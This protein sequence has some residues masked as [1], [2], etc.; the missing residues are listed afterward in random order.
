MTDAELSQQVRSALLRLHDPI[1]LRADPLARGFD[2]WSQNGRSSGPGGARLR[3]ELLD[4]IEALK[5]QPP[6]SSNSRAL[7]LYRLLQLRYVEGNDVAEV[8][9]ELA[10]SKSQYYREHEPALAALVAELQDRW[11]GAP[12]L[13]SPSEGAAAAGPRRIRPEARAAGLGR[14]ILRW[15]ATAAVA[16]LAIGALAAGNV[17]LLRQL[18]P[19]ADGETAR[20]AGAQGPASVAGATAF[21]IYAGTGEPG[22]ENGAAL[23]A[24]FA[25]PLGL[26]VDDS[27]TV[28]V[29]DTGNHRIRMITNTGL[30]LDLAGSGVEGYAD[31]SRSAAEFSSPNA[32][33]VGPN[34]LVYVADAGNLRIRAINPDGTV[35]TLAG[36]G[37]SGVR[38]GRGTEAEFISTAAIVAD[39]LGNLYVPDRLNNVVRKVRATG[40]VSW[41]AGSGRRG[42]VDGPTDVAEFNLPLRMAAD[43]AANVYV[44]DT[45]DNRI[46]KITPDGYVSTVAGTGEPG[47]SD[48]PSAE[49]RFS[50]NVMGICLDEAGN[51][52]ALD[53][54]NSRIRKV[55]P[56]G[57]VSTVFEFSGLDITP[58]NMKIDRAGSLYLS[59]RPHNMIYKVA[60]SART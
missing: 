19:L 1:A 47:F 8:Q 55:S 17:S 42:H 48:G 49:A 14:P 10:I 4:A 11:S 33:T 2:S 27:G 46:R 34:G 26:T 22:H 7:R 36:S 18:M 12:G 56:Q 30:V 37:Q 35:S 41:F 57:D 3:D 21:S 9:R 52:Y 20:S 53:A 54:G 39:R 60:R 32:L 40:D 43:A 5:P 58:A 23:L 13:A 29:A 59:D 24:R 45:G 38:D 31:G 28:Y 44:V 25:G 51:L 15:I 16:V 6:L 50:A